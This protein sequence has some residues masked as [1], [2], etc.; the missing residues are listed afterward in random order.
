[1]EEVKETRNMFRI[2]FAVVPVLRG[3]VHRSTAT[4][5]LLILRFMLLIVGPQ[6]N[7]SNLNVT[8]TNVTN[9]RITH[10]WSS[11]L[12]FPNL[13]LVTLPT[14]CKIVIA[15]IAWLNPGC[16]LHA[17]YLDTVSPSVSL[18]KL[19]TRLSHASSSVPPTPSSLPSSHS[20]PTN[21]IISIVYCLAVNW[22]TSCKMKSEIKPR[23]LWSAAQIWLWWPWHKQTKIT[24]I[25]WAHFLFGYL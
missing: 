19:P 8:L 11:C 17:V 5:K 24:Q 22:F 20:L 21:L 4:F 7:L 6:G 23:T 18:A 14:V 25:F 10:P 16:R 1:M 9:F 13:C 3:S 2:T 15:L 12:T